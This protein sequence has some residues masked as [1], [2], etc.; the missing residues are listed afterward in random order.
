MRTV[1]LRD[2]VVTELDAWLCWR[3]VQ[4]I[5]GDPAVVGALV[6]ALEAAQCVLAYYAVIDQKSEAGRNLRG[7]AGT[8]F[9]IDSVLNRVKGG[10]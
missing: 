10:A 4:D 9:Q 6:A 2:E 3:A 5:G 7:P 8:L 1:N